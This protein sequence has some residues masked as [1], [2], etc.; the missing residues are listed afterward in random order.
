MSSQGLCSC[1]VGKLAGWGDSLGRL[2]RKVRMEMS[3]PLGVP[4]LALGGPP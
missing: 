1:I 4:G 3:V 2:G